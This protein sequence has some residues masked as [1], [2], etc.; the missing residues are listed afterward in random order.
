MDEAVY[1][2][3]RDTGDRNRALAYLMHNA[4]SLRLPVDEVLDVYFRQC[5]VQVTTKDLAVMAATPDP[6]GP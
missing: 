6:R 1:R 2:S 5:A 4:G 3:E